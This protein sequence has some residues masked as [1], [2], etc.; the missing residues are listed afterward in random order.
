M[1][2][3]SEYSAHSDR[4]KFTVQIMNISLYIKVPVNI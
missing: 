3:I 2:V 4:A 1:K